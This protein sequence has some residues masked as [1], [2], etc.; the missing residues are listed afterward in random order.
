MENRTSTFLVE[1]NSFHL[2]ESIFS[3]VLFG[4]NQDLELLQCCVR[5]CS[6]LFMVGFNSRES[7][8]KRLLCAA[9]LE[10]WLPYA[11]NSSRQSSLSPSL[12]V[13]QN[14]MKNRV[15]SALPESHCQYMEGYNGRRFCVLSITLQIA[16]HWSVIL[17]RL[18][19][20]IPSFIKSAD[21]Y[22][23]NFWTSDL[24]VGRNASLL[25]P[26]VLM[27]MRFFEIYPDVCLLLSMICVIW[28]GNNSR[29]RPKEKGVCISLM[30]KQRSHFVF[31]SLIHLISQ[32]PPILTIVTPAPP[33]G[34]RKDGVNMCS[35]YTT[36]TNP[37]VSGLTQ[38]H[39]VISIHN[40][41]HVIVFS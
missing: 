24:F 6:A 34:S 10:I 27:K 4:K 15:S 9:C 39:H 1:R 5:I 41:P 17:E 33:S 23:M 19:I 22:S 37:T 29:L 13:K 8:S 30:S 25:K 7:L 40:A 16:E 11:L 28:N 36:Q 3:L 38:T 26:R 31:L 21:H 12:S 20:L 32:R 14:L 35:Y 18:L 2:L